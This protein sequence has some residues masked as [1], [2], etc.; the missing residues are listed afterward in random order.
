M[1]TK[2]A[3]E[4]L[5]CSLPHLLTLIE[6]GEINYKKIGNHRIVK[7]D[8]VMAYM[9]KMKARQQELLIKIM[10]ADEESGLYDS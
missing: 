1:T 8:D 4:L 6:E 5:G 7:L 3:A 10:T 2:S 9:K